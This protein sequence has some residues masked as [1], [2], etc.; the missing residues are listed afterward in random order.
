MASNP[1]S[2][3]TKELFDFYKVDSSKGLT[4]E[5]VLENRKLYGENGKYLINF[6]FYS[7]RRKKKK[8]V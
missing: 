4:S 7:I 5:Q 3:S 6:F 2:L 1:H 8:N